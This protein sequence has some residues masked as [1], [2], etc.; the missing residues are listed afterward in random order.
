MKVNHTILVF[1]ACI[2]P[3]IFSASAELTYTPAVFLDASR[4]LMS[5]LYHQ[6][7]YY[8]SKEDREIFHIRFN[9]AFSFIA[10]E[11][12]NPYAIIQKIKTKFYDSAPAPLQ[13]SIVL[14]AM[15]TCPEPCPHQ[16]KITWIGHATF[17]IQTEG[18]NVLTD[19]IFGDVK[20]GPF[21]LTSRALLPGIPFE[22]LP[23]IDVIVI[24]HNHSDHTDTDTL[25]KLAQKYDPIVFVPEGNKELIKSMGFSRVIENTWWQKQTVTKVDKHIE[26]SCVPAYHWSIRFSLG[27]Y[28]ASLWA[29][30]MIT[31]GEKNI[32]FAGDTA[33]GDHFKQIARV[34]PRIDI[35]LMPIGPTG[36]DH[37]T[38]K[39]CHVDAPEAVE[40]CIDLGAHRF[41]PM[42][43]GTFFL[44]NDTLT[45]PLAKLRA[46]WDQKKDALKDVI[47]TV[48][49][50]GEQL[51][52]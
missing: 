48:A 1:M 52:F 26:V 3:I 27:S 31:A 40:A 33:Y 32:Y 7:R 11:V 28:R 8:Y 14:N 9:K 37:N 13:P 44:S 42:H 25:V 49:R 29:G 16:S 45:Y 51:T 15:Q 21:T 20:A 30:W 36:K 4:D 5:P 23:P 38:H 12:L 2:C 24:S 6:G 22:C 39:E 34:F 43:Y 47:L 50:C 10:K 46:S 18:F 35:A 41:I 19:P 17:L